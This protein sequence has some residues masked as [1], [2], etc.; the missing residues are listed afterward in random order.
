MLKQSETGDLDLRGLL[1]VVLVAGWLTGILL[2]SW[3]ALSQAY[4]LFAA[5]LSLAV[6]TLLWQR[7]AARLF[8]LVLLCLC[9]GA[10]RYATIA[11]NNDPAAVNTLIGAKKLDL[12]GNVADEPRLEDHSTLLTINVQSASQDGGK[13]WRE[14]HGTIQAQTPGSVFADP[15]APHYG[16]NVQLTGSLTPPPAYGTPEMQA[17]MTFPRVTITSHGG[18]PLLVGL[19]QLRITL[20]AIL[21]QALPQP[22]AALLIAL[23]LSLRTPALKPL[24][25]LF[26]VTGCAHLI[27]PSGFKVTLF[28][29]LI[30]RG[31]G[32][33]VPRRGQQDWLLLPAQRR[34]GRWRRWLR[35][36]LVMLGIVVYTVLS[37]AGPAALRA[38]IMGC[39]LVLAPR[40]ERLYNVY[41]ALALTALL[42]SLADPFVLWDTGFQLSVIGTA[43]IVLLT[44][45]FQHLL[46][47]MKR[48]PWG[49]H[50]AEI[51]AVTL[52]A[53]VATLP[54]FCLSFN[55]ISFV[56][57]FANIATVPLLGL[58]LCLGALICLVGLLSM[59]LAL[60]CGWLAWPLLWYVTTAISWC[61]H[62]P[63][64]YVYIT[65]LNPLLAWGYYALLTGLTALLLTRWQPR[66]P[67]KHTHSA[68]L[69]S[70]RMRRA[71]QC[72]LAL[73][74]LLTTGI[75]AQVVRPDAHLTITLLT[76]GRGT[77]GQA[78]LLRTPDGQ[79]ALIDEDA[80]NA[81]LTEILDAQFPFWQRALSLVVLTDTSAVNLTG[82]QNVISRYSVARVIDAGMLH[83]SVAYARWHRALSE[84]SLAY[85]QVRQGATIAL[86]NQVAFQVLWPPAQLHKSSDETRDNALILRLLAPGLR[87]LLLN[88]ASLSAYALKALTES[89]T[90]LQ[91]QAQ[92]TQMGSEQGKTF[93]GPLIS[94]LNLAQPSLLLI[95]SLPTRKS[96]S[97]APFPTPP[98]GP[99]QT[100]N[101]EQS[102]SLHINA[103]GQHW[104]VVPAPGS[105]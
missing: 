32:W 64:A 71:L 26:N 95:T 68:P 7:H 85:T 76:D 104:D 61:A 69:F 6:A 42:M 13:T 47:F 40:L 19:Y 100:L 57:P 82:L 93:P 24:I 44:P 70:Q 94:V 9:L 96:H 87:M 11:P 28:A 27:A 74:M 65:N 25:P 17:S 58:L 101:A 73:C 50:A 37:G 97:T 56:A 103:Y 55:Q 79:N 78:L 105:S 3:L 39:L 63:G 35:T 83:P 36:S 34:R 89:V 49:E 92:I 1:L 84:R 10:W 67:G 59:P 53:Q 51:V 30:T 46:S 2:S 43:G 60:I 54:I 4:A 31:T 45:F 5:G 14:A 29:G 52:A 41:T 21:L 23:F 102:G 18:N 86:S 16:D 91:L 8:V 62:L 90:S 99:W 38:G 81:T 77:Q 72:A 66:K 88:S 48:L 33:L 98:R 22:E 80:D 75:M 15:Y 12:L 20:A